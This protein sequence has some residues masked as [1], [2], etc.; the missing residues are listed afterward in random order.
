MAQLGLASTLE[1]YLRFLSNVV[2]DFESENGLPLASM[3]GISLE[4]RI[5][6]RE[7]HRLA[8]YRGM[9]PVVIGLAEAERMQNHMYGSLVLALSYPF[10]DQRTRIEA[11]EL[12]VVLF[13]KFRISN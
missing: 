9:G 11:G 7:M 13:T 1:N 6:Y 4:R 5:H 12:Y 2:A 10:F 3:C 8:G